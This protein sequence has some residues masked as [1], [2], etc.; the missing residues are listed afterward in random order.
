MPPGSADQEPKRER[1]IVAGVVAAALVV[2]VVIPV[3]GATTHDYHCRRVERYLSTMAIGEVSSGAKD[4]PHAVAEVCFRPASDGCDVH[5]FPYVYSR[6]PASWEWSLKVKWSDEDGHHEKRNHSS[7]IGS[8]D[9]KLYHQSPR[10]PDTIREGDYIV[11]RANLWVEPTKTQWGAV[12]PW[13]SSFY[14]C[15]TSDGGGGGG[16]GGD[17]SDGV[18]PKELPPTPR[19]N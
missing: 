9:R 8:V 3:V 10:W 16:G 19:T 15:S 14:R 6:A 4:D 11:A 18:S 13:A 2:P 1:W 7:T 12:G 17:D 5:A